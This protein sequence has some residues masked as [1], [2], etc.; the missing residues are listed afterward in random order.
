MR[1]RGCVGQGRLS[2][3]SSQLWVFL[4]RHS[5]CHCKHED[6]FLDLPVLV[7]LP[8]EGLIFEGTIENGD[9]SA[10]VC[11]GPDSYKGGSQ[12]TQHEQQ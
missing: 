3:V 12:E 5:R 11:A 6:K 4:Q 9:D 1:R 2:P 8:F 7:H 10:N